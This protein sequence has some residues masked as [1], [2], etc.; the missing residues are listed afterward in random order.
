[1]NLHKSCKFQD[2]KYKSDKLVKRCKFLLL[3]SSRPH[4]TPLLALPLSLISWV[5]ILAEVCFHEFN[6]AP[7]SWLSWRLVFLRMFGCSRVLF[8]FSALFRAETYLFYDRG[9]DWS[10]ARSDQPI[11]GLHVRFSVWRVAAWNSYSYRWSCF[12]TLIFRIS[13]ISK[14]MLI[15]VIF[16]SLHSTFICSGEPGEIV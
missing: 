12:I 6:V 4:P 3:S 15:F 2:T 8:D 13:T 11:S 14:V 9:S 10:K 1:M 5:C 7:S 16:L